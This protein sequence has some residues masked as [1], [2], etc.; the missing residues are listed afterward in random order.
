MVAY[1]TTPLSTD[2]YSRVM[3]SSF[4][5]LDYVGAPVG[6]QA[7]FGRPETG[8]ATVYSPD[9]GEVDIDIIRGAGER[10]APLIPRGMLARPVGDLQKNL[11]TQ[12][13]TNFNRVYPLIEEESDLG[14][15][16]L[17]NR[18]AGENPYSQTQRIDR[19]RRLALRQHKEQVRRTIRTFEYLASQSILTGKMDAILGTLDTSLQYNFRRTAAH[20]ITLGVQWTSASAVI[21]SDLDDTWRIIRQNAYVNADGL[22]LGKDAMNAFINDSE[23]RALADNR[24]FELVYVSAENPVPSKFGWMVRAGFTPRGRVRTPEGHEFWMFTYD[25][26]Y[27]NSAGTTTEYMPAG[28]VLMFW[29]GARCDRFFGPPELLPMVP[30]RRQLYME[31]FGFSMDSPPMPPDLRGDSGVLNPGMFYFDAYAPETWKTVSLRMQAAP[32]FSTTQ[33]D[34]FA[35]LENAA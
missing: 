34:A 14:A 4:D 5:E 33:T 20:S 10:L 9:A 24:R 17:I 31:L 23:V 30:Q 3:A 25:D 35:V 16:Q 6:F 18:T 8:A 27:T 29:S 7:F 1:Q 32:I 28:K 2:L 22:V 26:I 12:K 15:G 21:M 19:L 13:F 11:Q